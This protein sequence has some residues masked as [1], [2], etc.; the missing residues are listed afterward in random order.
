MRQDV[1]DF[2]QICDRCARRK[3]GNIPKSPSGEPLVANEFLEILA[4]DFIGP[5]QT[6]KD[7]NKYI[8]TFV[9]HFTRYCFA[10]PLPEET[11]ERVAYELVHKII[12]HNGT[13]QYLLSDQGTQFLS[14]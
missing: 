5:L 9:D 14:K 1:V 4:A 8:L 13:P 2:I 7:G 6:T 10:I 12:L 11:A 3:D